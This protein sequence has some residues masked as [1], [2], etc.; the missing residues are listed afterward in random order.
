MTR[1]KIICLI[2]TTI[3]IL[4]ISLTIG[5]SAF[6][7]EMNVTGITAKVRLEENIRVTGISVES[8]EGNA[9]SSYED[10]NVAALL[11]EVTLPQSESS[12]TYKVTITNFGNTE[13]GVL[14]ID[15][16]PE[17]LEYELNGYLL[18]EKICNTNNEC[19]LGASKEFLITIKYKENGY[20][21]TTTYPLNLQLT[22][23]PFHTVSYVNISNPSYPSEVMDSTDFLV[24][25][26]DPKPD[27]VKVYNESN[28]EIPYIY[29]NGTLTIQNVK[30]NIIIE[31]T[32]DLSD[33]DF[34]IENDSDTEI[35]ERIANEGP[36]SIDDLISTTLTGINISNKIVSKIDVSIKYNSTTGSAQKINIILSEN[37]N[38]HTQ[39]TSLTKGNNTL[40]VTFDNLT[41]APEGEFNISVD[42]SKLTNHQIEISEVNI[43]IY[44]QS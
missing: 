33:K 9:Y 22:Y 41:L 14:S 40:T 25:F 31:E 16:L 38:E 4:I 36:I 28:T 6:G 21:G 3:T 26:L 32:K 35:Y 39:E 37:N 20:T 42:D 19:K 11:T 10:Y 2:A 12:I 29:E 27:R 23:K 43:K 18:Q 24:T 17:N 13:M 15:N 1:N 34:V 5:Y 7:T 8:T 44:F 30:E